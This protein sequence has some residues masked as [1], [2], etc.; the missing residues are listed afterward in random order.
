MGWSESS[1]LGAYINWL[2]ESICHHEIEDPLRWFSW[3]SYAKVLA[4]TTASNQD[5][6]A[7]FCFDGVYV[8]SL[9]SGYGFK[10]EES[11]KNIQFVQK[12]CVDKTW[13]NDF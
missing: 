10:S 4:D 5:F 11:W 8:D 9:L 12:V 6:V 13:K 1:N 7:K 3:I 2:C